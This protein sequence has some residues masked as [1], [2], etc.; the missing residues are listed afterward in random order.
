MGL[1]SNTMTGCQKIV[2]CFALLQT[3]V[4]GVKYGEWGRKV[5]P[6][7]APVKTDLL[8]WYTKRLAELRRLILK[9]QE[10]CSKRP[11]PTAF[12]TFKYAPLHHLHSLFRPDQIRTAAE[13]KA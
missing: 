7:L 6:G 12:V 11:G 8:D 5:Y 13:P 10:K 2:I 9:E 3:R 1:V 4:L